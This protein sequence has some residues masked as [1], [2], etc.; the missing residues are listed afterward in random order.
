VR[1]GET[2][3]W[4]EQE[5][6]IDCDSQILIRDFLEEVSLEINRFFNLLERSED[7]GSRNDR[8]AKNLQDLLKIDNRATL[9]NDTTTQRRAWCFFLYF[10]YTA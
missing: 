2:S 1:R 5:Q 4:S 3:E 9:H 10:E 8:T 6:T 7:R